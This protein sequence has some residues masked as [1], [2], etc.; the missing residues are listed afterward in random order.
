[1]ASSSLYPA[2]S[3]PWLAAFLVNLALLAFAGSAHAL[4]QQAAALLA[5]YRDIRPELADN[6]FGIPVYVRS[7]DRD[8]VLTAQVYGR[9]DYP[10]QRLK[11]ALTEPSGW[12]ELLALTLNVKACVHDERDAQQW[13]TLYVGRKVYQSPDEAYRMRYR[14]KV[15]ASSSGYLEASLSAP[16]GP[17]G[18]SDYH[19]VLQAVSIPGGTLIHIHSAYRSSTASRW[20]TSVYLATLGRG[21]IGFSR[22]GVDHDGQPIYVDGVRGVIER[23]TMRYYLALQTVLEIRDLPA[24][25]RFEERIRRWF[26]LTE[27]YRPQLH[28]MERAEYLQGKRRE[29]I[30][31]L[32]FQD[33]QTALASD[34]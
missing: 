34:Q 18:T 20:A 29:H 22:V 1:M 24:G 19:T 8:D 10:L 26:A 25:K 30:N 11:V 4:S 33:A 23:N 16:D 14:F 15:S 17:L 12:C 9:V 21:K 32:R 27:H 2:L 3:R 13:L 6:P 28:E 31:Q 5:D 7:R